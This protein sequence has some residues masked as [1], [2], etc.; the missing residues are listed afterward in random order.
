MLAPEFL[1]GGFA[2]A[3]GPAPP[4]L[5]ESAAAAG[6]SVS[7]P[8]SDSRGRRSPT[9]MGP[10][11]VTEEVIAHP[12]REWV[13]DRSVPS[14]YLPQPPM[15][16]G[17]GHALAAKLSKLL[18][19]L[20][21]R[22]ECRRQSDRFFVESAWYNYML[23][24]DEYDRIYEPAVFAPTSSN[25]LSPHKLACV[26]MVLTLD[27]FLD[28]TREQE[29]PKVAMYWDATQECFD[30]RFGWAASLAGVQALGLMTYFVGFGW[31]GARAS[32]FYWLRRM[33]TATQQLGMHK[34]PHPSLPKYEANLRRRVFH[35]SYVIDTLICINHGHRNAINIEN[36]ECRYPDESPRVTVRYDYMRTVNNTILDYGLR[37]DR[38]AATP[39]EVRV[40][41]EKVDQFHFEMLPQ[42]HCP[43]LSGAP[44]PDPPTTLLMKRD[45]TPQEVLITAI[46]ANSMAMNKSIRK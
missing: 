41:E 33:T 21:P 2:T 27:S 22:E 23:Q 45:L 39:E 44:I 12:D 42:W 3:A 30:T 31:K 28:L 13:S 17:S 9:S 7:P 29:D 34:D 32:N 40:I 25:P 20:P 1:D 38:I 24:R 8:A 15:L 46:T 14:Q 36:I 19:V 18:S 4:P 6:S 37:P 16:Q 43:A 26:L 10:A 35:E 11:N 5:G